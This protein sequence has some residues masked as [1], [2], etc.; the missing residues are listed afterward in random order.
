MKKQIKVT[1]GNPADDIPPYE[2]GEPE[3]LDIN[4]APAPIEQEVGVF[5]MDEPCPECHN[6]HYLI[7]RNNNNNQYRAKC[8]GDCEIK[9]AFYAWPQ[10]AIDALQTRRTK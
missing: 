2:M 6:N 9:T 7:E 4:E 5:D 3:K 10:M 8:G 1:I